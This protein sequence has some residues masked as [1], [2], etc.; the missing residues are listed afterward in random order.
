MREAWRV[1]PRYS[2]HRGRGLD[3]HLAELARGASG[4]TLDLGEE[5]DAWEADTA[6]CGC[7]GGSVSGGSSPS[8]GAS[9]AGSIDVPPAALGA[10][11]GAGASHVLPVYPPASASNFAPV[12]RH[13]PT[14]DRGR[15]EGFEAMQRVLAPA[16]ASTLRAR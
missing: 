7:A 4:T 10:G 5:E 8:A 2:T 16:L 3:E 15:R 14:L 13:V 6:S 11:S 1:E 9:P 12:C